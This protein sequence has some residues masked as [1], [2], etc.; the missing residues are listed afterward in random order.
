MA[1]AMSL[2]L[3]LPATAGTDIT[4]FWEVAISDWARRFV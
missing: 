2:G 1:A 4:S 3:D